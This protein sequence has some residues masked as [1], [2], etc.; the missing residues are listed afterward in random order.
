MKRDLFIG[1]MSGTSIDGVDSALVQIKN[2]KIKLLCSYF[3]KFDKKIKNKLLN[4]NQS[5]SDEINNSQLVQN[6]LTILYSEVI[7][8]LLKNQNLLEIQ[9]K[10]LGVMV[11]LL[12][13]GQILAI[14]FS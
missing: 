8:K 5:S 11:K 6:E 7:D 9:L 3:Q 14:Q 1:L 12:D 10:R 4:L 2:K 13:I